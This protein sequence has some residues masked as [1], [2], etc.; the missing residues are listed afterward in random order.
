MAKIFSSDVEACSSILDG[1]TGSLVLSAGAVFNVSSGIGVSMVVYRDQCNL[2]AQATKEE[3]LALCA[4]R[5]S[6]AEN[7]CRK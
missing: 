5:R 7:N 6:L 3:N 4:Y 1:F 2:V